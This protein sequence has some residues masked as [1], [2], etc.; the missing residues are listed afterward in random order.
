[1]CV[2]WRGGTGVWVCVSWWICWL[3]L[4]SDERKNCRKRL[5]GNNARYS[6][7]K[8]ERIIRHR[9][10]SVVTFGW[11]VKR[12]GQWPETGVR[13]QLW[14]RFRQFIRQNGHTTSIGRSYQHQRSVQSSRRYDDSAAGDR[15][16]QDLWSGLFNLLILKIPA[17]A[18]VQASVLHITASNILQ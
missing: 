2:V 16:L 17:T 4:C 7:V 9:V 1:M 14:A 3:V 13:I 8:G 5:V 12:W 15:N 10:N 18:T 11:P 6:L